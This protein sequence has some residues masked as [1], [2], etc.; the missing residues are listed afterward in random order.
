MSSAQLQ[1]QCVPQWCSM[2]G[3]AE[4]DVAVGIDQKSHKVRRA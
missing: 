3:A 2:T 1:N 4:T